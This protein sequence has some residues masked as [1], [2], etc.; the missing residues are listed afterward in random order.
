MNH[1]DNLIAS[2][3]YLFIVYCILHIFNAIVISV[4]N[5]MRCQNTQEYDI[6]SLQ[7]ENDLL[8]KN[9]ERLEKNISQKQD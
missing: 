5:I 9:I 1:I 2:F 6:E 7:I 3:V 8:R 4:I